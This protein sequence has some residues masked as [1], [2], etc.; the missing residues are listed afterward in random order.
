MLWIEGT[1]G[2][3]QAALELSAE[4]GRLEEG[5]SDIVMPPLR[6]DPHGRFSVPGRQTVFSGGPQRIDEAPMSKPV[7]IT[8]RVDGAILILRIAASGEP[9]RELAFQRGKLTKIHRCY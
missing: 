9:P 4:G 1:W 3:P 2:A 5:C 7:Q 6:P 8:G